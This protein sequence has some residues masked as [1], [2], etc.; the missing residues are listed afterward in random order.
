MHLES[1][2]SGLAPDSIKDQCSIIIFE[3]EAREQV[4]E[5][6]QLV[7][8]RRTKS[9]EKLIKEVNIRFRPYYYLLGAVILENKTPKS[10]MNRIDNMLL[11]TE[12]PYFSSIAAIIAD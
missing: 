1:L 8:K 12:R 3:I 7:K 9:A 6:I 4:E 2:N 10:W 11:I 5:F